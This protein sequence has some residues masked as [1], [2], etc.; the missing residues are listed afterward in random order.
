MRRIAIAVMS[1]ISG[2]VLLFSYHTSLGPQGP[3]SGPAAGG[4]GAPPGAAGDGGG[5]T[6]QD[7]TG[8]SAGQDPGGSAAPTP[9]GTQDQQNTGGS[10]GTFT[11]DEVATRWGP[12]QVRVVIRSGKITQ[13]QA[14][15]YPTGNHRDQQ[16]NSWAIPQLEDATVRANSAQID[17]VG[18]ATVTSQGY[19]ASLQSALDKAHA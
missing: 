19:I 18:G 12:V 4:P 7:D 5:A 14:V 6:A 15:E 8:G 16:I 1:T 13:A 3:A 2:L 11:G 17:S 10:S 9:T